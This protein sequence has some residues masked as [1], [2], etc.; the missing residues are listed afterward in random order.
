LSYCVFPPVARTYRVPADFQLSLTT[1]LLDSYQDGDTGKAC[2][3]SM[4]A[5][6]LL[7]AARRGEYIAIDIREPHEVLLADIPTDIASQKLPLSSLDGE[8]DVAGFFSLLR[9]HQSVE[10]AGNQQALVYC[11]AGQRS[12]TFVERYSEVA[13]RAG[14]ELVSLPGGVNGLQAQRS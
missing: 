8:D 6:E 9:P 14:I 7:E 5:Q 12:N 10:L 4:R 11:A 13:K 2:A 1:E 3:V